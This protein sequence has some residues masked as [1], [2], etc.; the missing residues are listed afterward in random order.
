MNLEPRLNGLRLLLVEDDPDTAELFTFIFNEAG[1]EVIAVERV[2]EALKMLETYFPDMLISEIRL[3]FEDGYSLI[4]KV[5]IRSAELGRRITAIAVTT[6][7]S[8]SERTRVLLAGFERYVSKPI[9]PDEL[10]EVVAG[11]VASCSSK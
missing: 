3:P 6:V 11:N 1:A 10:I 8:C 7:P 5:K 2:T 9:Q 4:E